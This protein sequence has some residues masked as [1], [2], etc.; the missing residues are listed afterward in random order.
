MKGLLIAALLMTTEPNLEQDYAQ[1]LDGSALAMVTVMARYPDGRPVRGY[2]QCSGNWFKH[3]DG[4]INLEAQ[5]M[6]FRTDSRGAVILNPHLSDEWLI[7]WCEQD[8][9]TGHVTVSFDSADPT[10]VFEIVMG[11]S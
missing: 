2:I 5:S 11:E 1:T 7:C 9:M 10:G 6:P 3:Q 8:G 4:P